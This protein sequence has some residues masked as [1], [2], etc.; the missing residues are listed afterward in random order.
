MK[1]IDVTIPFTGWVSMT[2]VVADDSTFESETSNIL[3]AAE[4]QFNIGDFPSETSEGKYQETFLQLHERICSGNVCHA[5]VNEMEVH[6]D[7]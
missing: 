2:V 1:T 4:E 6:E 5:E 7:E 3:A